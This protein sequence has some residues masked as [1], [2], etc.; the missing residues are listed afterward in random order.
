[1]DILKRNN[2]IR[3]GRGAVPMLFS[4]GYGCDQNMWRYITSAFEE[5]YEVY[6]FDHV[7]SGRSQENAYDPEKYSSLEGYASDVVEICECLGLK[8]TIFVGHSVSAMIGVLASIKRPS[9]F[10]Q[11]IMVGPSA[12]YINQNGYFGGFNESDIMELVETLES[13]YLGW[14]SHIAPVITGRPDKPEFSDELNNSFCSMNPDIAKQFA[15]VTF[16]GDNRK[17]LPKVTIP[18][19]VIQSNPDTIAPVEVGK[20]IQ[21]EIPN[22]EYIELDSPGHC[23]HLTEPQQTI[24]AIKSYLNLSK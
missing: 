14:A 13:N 11:L 20:Y 12:K 3:F 15:K 24:A 19:L 7:G 1:M 4:H 2:I 10:S 8:D 18:S 22:C 23:P 6:L 9:L 16:L 21:S 17:D 5:D